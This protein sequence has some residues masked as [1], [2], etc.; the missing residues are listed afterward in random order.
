MLLFMCTALSPCML[1]CCMAL[2]LCMTLSPYI[3]CTKAG[4]VAL[5][6]KVVNNP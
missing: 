5:M 3:S 1:E 2:S 6:V 4:H